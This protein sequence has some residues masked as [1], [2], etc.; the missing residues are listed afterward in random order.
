MHSVSPRPLASTYENGNP[1]FGSMTG[2]T[3]IAACEGAA[4]A[5]ARNGA[6]RPVI[7]VAKLHGPL[8]VTRQPMSVVVR[9][10]AAALGTSTVS[11]LGVR[12]RVRRAPWNGVVG[13]AC[14]RV[15]GAH[16]HA[17]D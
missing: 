3:V 2:E 12:D 14:A 15:G 7:A 13:E 10:R 1:L 9:P 11:V 4:A 17:V 16:R 6:K 8:A 5:G